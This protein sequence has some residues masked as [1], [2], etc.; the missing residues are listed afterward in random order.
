MNKI[1]KFFY[2][3]SSFIIASLAT[4]VFLAY[5]INVLDPKSAPFEIIDEMPKSLGT[6]FGFGETEILIY[7]S[8]RTNEMIQSYINFNLIWDSLFGVLYG[9][10]Y[11]LWLSYLYRPFHNKLRSINLLPFAQVLFDWI[12]NLNLALISNNYL[13]T[14]TIQPLYSQ[15]ASYSNIIKWIISLLVILLIIIGLVLSIMGFIKKKLV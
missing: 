13:K 6:M 5:L 11:T 12:E 4:I 14:E 15:F 8:I 1:S 10:M 2:N 3:K 9:T 7:L